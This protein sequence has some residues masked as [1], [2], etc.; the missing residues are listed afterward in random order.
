MIHYQ[1]FIDKI[2]LKRDTLIALLEKWVNVNSHSDHLLGLHKMSTLLEEAFSELNGTI[3]TIQL[4]DRYGKALSISKRLDAP[5]RILLGG[6]MD[7]VYPVDSPFQHAVRVDS[8]SIRGPG[9]TDMKGGLVILLAA[10][11]ALEASPF[12]PK[13]G[14]EVFINP[15]EEIGSPGSTPEWTKRASQYHLGLLFEPSFPDG[16][17]VSERKGSV[18]FTLHV[19]GR[20]A[21]SGRD[22]HAGKNAITALARVV[23]AADNLQNLKEGLTIN[24]G[25]FTGGGAVNIVPDA[26]SCR[27]NV[28]IQQAQDLQ[29][30][31]QRLNTLVEEA[32]TQEGILVTLQ[33]DSA[34]SPKPFDEKVKRLYEMMSLCA[35]D[36]GYPLTWRPSGGVSDGNILGA[37]G[38]PII[39]TMGAI[40]GKIHTHDEYIHLDSLTERAKLTALFLMKL[41]TQEIQC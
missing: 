13:I 22:F 30:I 21:H 29:F 32:N 35:Q 23:V 15:D 20:S 33:E 39:D 17:I 3:K 12:A 28:R 19:K 11:Q 31:R 1:P 14:W 10:L 27:I 7:T 40:G 34:R 9:C 24:V 37:L 6:H 36:L 25:S 2:D 8:N 18:N 16:A 26:A 41:S 5:I 4:G 38:L